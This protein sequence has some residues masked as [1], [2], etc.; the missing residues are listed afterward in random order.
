[1]PFVTHLQGGGGDDDR[2]FFGIHQ[3]T[4]VDEL[5]RKQ[6][7]VQVAKARLQLDG[8]GGCIDLV[9][10]A[11]QLAD[12]DFLFI[13]T[14]PGFNAERFAR[15]LRLHHRG[16]AVFRQGEDHINRVRLGENHNPGGVP[17]GD[18]VADIH[19]L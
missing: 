5:V 13:G 12:A 17:A 19:L 11:Q 7:V 2:V 14:I 3:Q 1:M 16:D 15:F 8:P 9:V 4:G 6:R 18:L 10:E